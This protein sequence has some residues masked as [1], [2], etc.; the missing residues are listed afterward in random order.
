MVR[1]IGPKKVSKPTP[2]VKKKANV[3]FLSKYDY[4]SVASRLSIGI[5]RHTDW[6]ANVITLSHIPQSIPN[7]NVMYVRETTKKRLKY[8][9]KR[10]NVVIWT[11]SFWG[12]YP[13]DNPKEYK[14][15]PGVKRGIWHGG[16]AYR[17][18]FKHFN[19]TVHPNC[20]YVFAHRDL[21][22]LDSRTKRLQAPFDTN[23]YKPVKRSDKTIFVSH[24]PS[25]RKMKG[26]KEFLNAMFRVQKKYS[27][28]EPMLIEDVNNTKALNMKKT[29]HI[30]FDQM[31]G[32]HIPPGATMGYGLSLI[33]A[34][35]FGCAT[36]CWS[37]YKDTP[38]ICVRSEDDIYEAIVRL[39][40]NRKLLQQTMSRNRSWVQKEHGYSPVARRFI[41]QLEA[42][43]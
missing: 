31:N 2:P 14:L 41:A 35:S 39:V 4:G 27:Y 34:S 38:I 15:K 37:N 19:D 23:R 24:S 13:Y 30:F 12:Y 3:L 17:T 42:K 36:L 16:T 40:K 29:S 6:S 11:S 1:T 22:G 20:D 8:F 25:S 9:M 10:A 7:P 33:E 5:N 43:L 32:Y 21:A 28:V 26:T 18:N